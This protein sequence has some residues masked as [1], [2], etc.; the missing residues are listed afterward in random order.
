LPSRDEPAVDFL[1]Q[2]RA[3][4]LGVIANGGVLCV[5]KTA[6]RI[7]HPAI[8]ALE[9]FTGIHNLSLGASIGG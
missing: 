1:V 5:P 3:D 2:H 7:W 4:D 8:T 9:T 6:R